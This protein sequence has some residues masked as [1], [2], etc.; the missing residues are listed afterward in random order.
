MSTPSIAS[1]FAQEVVRRP[2]LQHA[3][4]RLGLWLAAAAEQQGGFPVEVFQVEFKDGL[5]NDK[6]DAPGVNFRLETIAKSIEALKEEGLLTVEVE[7]RRGRHVPKLYTL[8][9]PQ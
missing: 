4:V 3:A 9:V 1:A 7:Q 5:H 2:H 6:I 8:R